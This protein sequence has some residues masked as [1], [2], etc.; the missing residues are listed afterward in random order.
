MKKIIIIVISIAVL[1]SLT[2]CGARW[3]QAKKNFESAYSGGIERRI[4]VYDCLTNEIIWSYEGKGYIDGNSTVGNVSIIYYIN[5]NISKKVDFIGNTI[6]VV[7][8]EI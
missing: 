5:D 3:E 8:E 7:S 6:C 4:S 2:S 1:M